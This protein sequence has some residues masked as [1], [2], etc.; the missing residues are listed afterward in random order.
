MYSLQSACDDSKSGVVLSM[1]SLQSA[2][3]DSKA[4]ALEIAS[5]SISFESFSNSCRIS[6]VAKQLG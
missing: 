5:A 2:C 3:N 1:Y 6:P 4:I